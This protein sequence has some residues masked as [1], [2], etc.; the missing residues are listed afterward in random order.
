LG[1]RARS[2]AAGWL[3]GRAAATTRWDAARLE[4][5][6]LRPRT[7]L[8]AP[9]ARQ[10][11]RPARS[12]LFRR[13]IGIADTH[14]TGLA[15]AHSSAGFAPGAAFLPAQPRLV[16]S[17]PDWIGTDRRQPIRSLAQ[18]SRQQ[19]QG[20]RG[21]AVLFARWGS[22]PFRQKALLRVS[23]RA[24]PRSAPMPRPH[25]GEPVPVE[26]T[27]P[28]GEGL[29]VPSS[30]LVGCRRVGCAMSDGPQG[31]GALDLRGRSAERA[32]QAGQG[33]PLAGVSG[34]RGSVRWRDRGHL[35][36]RGSPRH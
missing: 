33:D 25:S 11:W 4:R 21:R 23:A 35:G 14:P 32:A 15:V 26:A 12:A 20:P 3:V 22:R 2:R 36:A 34:R 19:A 27:D 9:A 30:D 8:T 6:P 16:Q 18:G 31:S 24:D 13:R 5:G 17:A 1:H 10:A 7:R 28:G 29:G